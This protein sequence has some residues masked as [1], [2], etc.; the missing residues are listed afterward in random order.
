MNQSLQEDWEKSAAMK[1]QRDLEEK[2]FERASDKLFL[3]DQC[4]KYR[5]CKQCQ[6][7]TS[8]EG[9][10]NL[11]PLNKYLRGSRFFV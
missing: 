5:R 7:R 11:W 3:L 8:N 4:E 2:A 9:G 10:S 1:R 6:R